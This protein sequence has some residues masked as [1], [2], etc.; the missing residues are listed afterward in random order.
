MSTEIQGS[1][2]NKTLC[3]LISGHAG[4]GKTYSSNNLKSFADSNE[5]QNYEFHFATPVK[6]IAQMMGWDGKKDQK[7]RR[8]LQAIGQA[9]RAYDPS[10]WVRHTFQAIEASE[11]FPFDVVFIDDWRFK[12]ELSYIQD[13]QP[14]YKVVTI[15]IQS[16][17]RESLK[18]TPEY[19]EISETELD[20]FTFQYTLESDEN[21]SQSL[22][23]IYLRE[24]KLNS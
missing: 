8:F 2:F 24:C 19:N 10:M 7:G 9:G 21:L 13:T 12:N 14:L 6:L 3:F 4:V 1:N 20:G 15:R 17:E 22:H 18:G 5:L 16:E 23:E 11:L